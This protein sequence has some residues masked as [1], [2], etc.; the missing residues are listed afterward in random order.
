V[1]GR[2]TGGAGEVRGL[3]GEALVLPRTVEEVGELFEAHDLDPDQLRLVEAETL[4][5]GDAV[6]WARELAARV[7]TEA[8]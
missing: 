4:G 8:T 1:L 2:P 5:A 7:A 6:T 3:G